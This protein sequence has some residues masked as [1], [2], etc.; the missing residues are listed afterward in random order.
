MEPSLGC[1]STD[2]E[3][4]N[5]ALART[6]RLDR[7]RLAEKNRTPYINE[8]QGKMTWQGS[9]F[10]ASLA[11]SLRMIRLSLDSMKVSSGGLL[12]SHVGPAM[13]AMDG[14]AGA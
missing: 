10:K 12:R 9:Q 5:V 6:Q 11:F 14:K 1:R 13:Q 7:E 4:K 8:S 2:V 3:R